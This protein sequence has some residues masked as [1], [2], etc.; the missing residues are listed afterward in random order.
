[1]SREK[2][3]SLSTGRS[4]DI[5]REYFPDNIQYV[6][7]SEKKYVYALQSLQKKILE[8][9]SLSRA[10]SALDI[11]EVIASL[12]TALSFDP[13]FNCEIIYAYPVVKSFRNSSS[14]SPNAAK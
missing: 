7:G 4:A 6:S 8:V 10:P 1:M 14:E 13:D 12:N 3:A 2:Y 11:A 5:I 9:D